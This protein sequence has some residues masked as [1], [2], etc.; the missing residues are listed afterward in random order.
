MYRNLCLHLRSAI[1]VTMILVMMLAG[2]GNLSAEIYRWQDTDGVIRYSNTPPDDETLLL[3]VIP[4]KRIPLIEDTNGTVYYL[5]VPEGEAAQEIPVQDMIDQLKL[6]PDVIEQILREAA[7]AAEPVTPAAPTA[8]TTDLSLMAVRL[9]ELESTLEREIGKR[10]QREQAYLE[11]QSKASVL[12]QQNAQ[13]KLEVDRVESQL[14]KLQKTVTLTDMQ[15]ANLQAPSSQGAQ[16]ARD[17]VAQQKIQQ[18]AMVQDEIELLKTAQTERL[19]T[20]TARLGQLETT[21]TTL[22]ERV[23]ALSQEVET[24]AAK[25]APKPEI[26]PAVQQQLAALTTTQ[27]Q[28]MADVQSEL[29]TLKSLQAEHLQ[30]LDAR[31]E[32]M[33]ATLTDL[34]ETALPER[35]AALSEKMEKL[36]AQPT[37]ESVSEAVL[38][39][40]LDTLTTEQQQRA[41]LVQ[42]EL[43]ALKTAQA[44]RLQTVLARLNTLE[45]TVTERDDADLRTQVTM[46]ARDVEEIAAVNAENPAEDE[47]L[48][49]EKIDTL[50]AEQTQQIEN[51]ATR[52]EALNDMNDSY[53]SQLGQIHAKLDD[54]ETQI[55]VQRQYTPAMTRETVAQAP[56]S[57]AQRQQFAMFANEIDALKQQIAAVTPPDAAQIE[58]IAMLT[59]EID[60]LK[61]QFAVVTTTPAPAVPMTLPD[62]AQLV[63]QLQEVV[64]QNRALQGIVRQ[65]AQAL[66]VQQGHIQTI[67]AQ[68]AAL[69]RTS[70]TPQIES[71]EQEMTTNGRIK[72]SPRYDR[73]LPS[74]IT[75]TEWVNQD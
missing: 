49:V 14:A 22:P 37:S 28:Q 19:Q 69:P 72:I 75:F 50:A 23:A 25:P 43:D 16:I 30:T 7:P 55:A 71:V 24:L 45:S 29:Q 68:L 27:Q 52:L 44:E 66:D 20:L 5:N 31:V 33:H 47:A 59:H 34:H 3:D 18:V 10:Q 54:F 39:R 15:L 26:A 51:L 21:L 1:S 38:Q 8:G 46:L 48:I 11:A 60:A 6:P 61:Q 13:L 65:Q 9:S 53:S 40:T 4:T 2:I 41:A 67:Q 17:A 36:T 56:E 35:V 62:A 57:V 73:R 42:S 32:Q 70:A 64:A 12:E 74:Q 63:A 58:Q